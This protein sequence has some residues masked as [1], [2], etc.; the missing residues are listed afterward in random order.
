MDKIALYKKAKVIGKS[1]RLIC[2]DSSLKGIQVSKCYIMD[3][4]IY[5]EMINNI[6]KRHEMFSFELDEELASVTKELVSITVSYDNYKYFNIMTLD[7]E[8]IVDFSV[9]DRNG[10]YGVVYFENGNTIVVNRKEFDEFKRVRTDRFGWAL[11]LEKEETGLLVADNNKMYILNR[12]AGE[13]KNTE[14]IH[15]YKD[16]SHFRYGA[17]L[18][19]TLNRNIKCSIKKVDTYNGIY[20]TEIL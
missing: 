8:S 20:N 7:A 3:K 17:I 5:V 18:R 13:Y 4:T 6:V 15:L 11:L 10:I 2:I 1:L 19:K 16:E 12:H 9:K 14:I